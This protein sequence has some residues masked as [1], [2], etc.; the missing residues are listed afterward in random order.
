MIITESGAF[1]KGHHSSLGSPSLNSATLSTVRQ[2]LYTRR[3]ESFLRCAA[4]IN[5]EK[6]R[7]RAKIRVDLP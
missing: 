1:R 4:V 6:L 2:R 5:G 3:V 7:A